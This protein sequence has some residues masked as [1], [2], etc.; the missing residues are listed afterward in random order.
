MKF[1]RLPR[2]RIEPG[3]VLLM[4]TLLPKVLMPVTLKVPPVDMFV[5]IV[6]EADAVATKDN[7]A[8]HPSSRSTL[9]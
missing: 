5:L 3:V 8:T 6:V 1:A 7:A 4:P 2:E 9:I